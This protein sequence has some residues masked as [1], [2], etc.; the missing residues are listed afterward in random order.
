MS[1][2]VELFALAYKKEQAASRRLAKSTGLSAQAALLQVLQAVAQPR[3]L[4][5]LL[6][7]RQKEKDDAAARIAL[8]RQRKADALAEKISAAKPDPTAWL[9]WFD[10]ATHPNPGK[11]GVGGVLQSPAGDMM[12]FSYAIGQGDSN[13]A[14]YM[15]LI[16][17]LQAAVDA[18]VAKLVVHGDS[19]VVL[20]D[21]QT[22]TAGIT[23]LHAQRI[24]A[25]QLLA[26][27]NDVSFRWIPR[28]KNIL[29]DAL[30][31]QA[32]TSKSFQLLV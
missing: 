13:Q 19:R 31:Q 2:A 21:V 24:Q 8:R 23:V 14:E 6:A 27:L 7:T 11:M 32:V 28:R 25:R 1:T 4:A 16:A 17:I 3:T 12:T 5:D 9:A 29:A 22:S 15:A 18:G 10:G 20:D 26:L 30:S